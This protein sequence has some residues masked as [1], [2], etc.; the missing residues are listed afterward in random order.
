MHSFQVVRPSSFSEALDILHERRPGWRVIAGGTDLMV[1]LRNSLDGES[2]LKGLVDLSGLDELRGFETADTEHHV[3]AMTTFAE[4]CMSPLAKR[5][6]PLLADM[7]W[8]MG[9]P[10]IRNLATVG[11]N[12]ANSATAADSIPPLLALC[13]EV[14]L[15]SA[16][17]TRIL[18]LDEFIVGPGR[19]DIRPD[20]ILTRISF[21]R[22]P[23]YTSW[24]YTKVGR[25][26]SAAISRASVAAVYLPAR[27]GEGCICRLAV[28][29]VTPKPVRLQK[30]E[31]CLVKDDWGPESIAR[32]AVAAREEVTAIT[33]I[34]W[35][36]AY[37]L[38]VLE[39]LVRRTLEGMNR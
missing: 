29:A 11:G 10:Q 32:A 33:G 26:K 8:Q 1:H 30:A 22:L 5:E 21:A 23:E 7:A 14:T 35:S 19:T 20:E 24:G 2:G 17:G 25:R 3:G 12:L 27:A 28:G 36:S 13:A 39:N 15:V 37:K 16:S 9:S 34:R 6:A 38:P 4:I 18:P 31:Q